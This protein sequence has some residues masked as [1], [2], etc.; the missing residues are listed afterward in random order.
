MANS[1]PLPPCNG[2]PEGYQYNPKTGLCESE[3]VEDAIWTG[4]TIPI[5]K[6]CVNQGYSA[7]GLRL[8][9]DVSGYTF[10]ISGNWTTNSSSDY[11]LEDNIGGAIEILLGA[12]NP[13]NPGNPSAILKPG[14]KSSLWGLD[15]D[16]TLPIN[17]ID[18]LITGAQ[19]NGRLNNAGIWLDVPFVCAAPQGS[20]SFD[21]CVN[22]ET[23]KQYLIGLGGDNECRL[24]VDGNLIVTLNGTTNQ[25]G[26][27]LFWHVI[28]ITL[29]AGQHTIT[30]EGFN[31]S[32]AASFAGEIY[33]ITLSEFQTNLTD[34]ADF[35][36]PDFPDSATCGNVYEDLLPYIIFTTQSYID[37]DIP[38]LTDT[39]GQWLCNGSVIEGDVCGTTP[40]CT[41]KDTQIPTP[42]CYLI[43]PCNGVGTP[44]EI[45]LDPEET[46]LLV[47]GN[48]YS[49]SDPLN[50]LNELGCFT[51]LDV[52]PCEE[53]SVTNVFVAEDHQSDNCNICNTYYTLND[54]VTDLPIDWPG[55]SGD[56]AFQGTIYLSFDGDCFPGY[57]IPNPVFVPCPNDIINLVITYIENEA[58]E[59]IRG[60]LKLTEILRTDIPEDAFIADWEGI[61]QGVAAVSDCPE[62]LKPCYKLIDCEQYPTIS[63]ETPSFEAYIGKVIQWQDQLGNV[64]CATVEKYLCK[65][66]VWPTEPIVVLDCFNLCEECLPQPV[67]EPVFELSSRSVRPGYNTP[68]C[69]A[70]YYEKVNCK[71]S[72]AVYQEMIAVRYGIKTCCDIDMRKYQIKKEMLNLD[73]LLDPNFDCC[74]LSVN[75]C[76]TNISVTCCTTACPPL[77]R[78]ILQKCNEPEVTEV[79][80]IDNQYDVLGNVIV[81][82]DVCYTVVEITHR[83][84]TVYWTPGTIYENCTDAGCPPDISYNCVDFNCVEVQGTGGTYQTLLECQTN[85]TAPVFLPCEDCIKIN[86][87]P[88][89]GAPIEIV[90][91]PTGTYLN[92]TSYYS[93]TIDN[94]DYEIYNETWNTTD[95]PGS[96]LLYAY[97]GGDE[98]GTFDVVGTC[99]IGIYTV[100]PDYFESFVIDY[101]GGEQTGFVLYSV[102]LDSGGNSGV[103][104]TYLDC[105]DIVQQY[106]IPAQRGTTNVYVC[107]KPGRLPTDFVA[108]G[109]TDF[110]VIE[111]L[112][113]CNC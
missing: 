68:G 45:S 107:S 97:D 78:Y 55:S 19:Y 82:D 38:D 67:P 24:Y 22:L 87:T 50:I 112:V 14:H 109:G 5:V 111:T 104:F 95:P 27:F 61:M 65:D 44:L 40:T 47:I 35:V 74:P 105:N 11:Y 98:I 2:C 42:C 91:P 60:C 43:N 31:V 103:Y 52:Q 10:P 113:P 64:H 69:P 76:P 63:T 92:G 8:Y 41:F 70:D 108:T 71:F 15:Y 3:I 73:A 66:E 59:N 49:F 32:S 88:T 53:V 96:W 23:S 94:I 17:C 89:G 9:E 7:D 56:P 57:T 90:V 51:V 12:A 72:E 102:F 75:C 83:L 62:C 93:F 106:D 33:D 28:P 13:A 100:D 84:V 77:T 101:C 29:T 1:N 46:T 99:P 110:N 39:S 81:I 26:P 21:F 20:V 86:A 37:N 34:T 6:G 30:L 4:A 85:C 79:V 18:P 25:R 58:S 80:R 36:D 16:V 48:I 54:C